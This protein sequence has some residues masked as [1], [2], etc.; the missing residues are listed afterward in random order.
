MLVTQVRWSS[1]NY[2]Y[3]FLLISVESVLRKWC[4][5]TVF[6]VLWYQ[7]LVDRALQ[8]P[9]WRRDWHCGVRVSKSSRLVGFISAIPATLRIYKQWVNLW[10]WKLYLLCVKFIGFANKLIGVYVI[11]EG[12]NFNSGNYLFTT[13]TK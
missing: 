12:W 3:W 9:G 4:W 11:Y 5:D 10:L 8:P 6:C 13:D 7:Y 1:D 2:Q